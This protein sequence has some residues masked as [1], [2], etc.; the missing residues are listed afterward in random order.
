MCGFQLHFSLVITTCKQGEGSWRYIIK[1]NFHVASDPHYMF[2]IRQTM[3]ILLF[4]EK[5]KKKRIEAPSRQLLKES[6]SHGIKEKLTPRI[7]NIHW[8]LSEYA[9][10]RKVIEKRTVNNENNL[11]LDWNSWFHCASYSKNV[12]VKC[13]LNMSAQKYWGITMSHW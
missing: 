12:T 7:L 5:I 3:H 2:E 4:Q 1:L 6:Y 11:R 13:M 9:A 8:H 10:C